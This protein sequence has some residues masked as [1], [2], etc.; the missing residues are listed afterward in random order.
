MEKISVKA[1]RNYDIYITRGYDELTKALT[2]IS[3]A[4]K[5]AIITDD[6]VK[7]L[8][9]EE[10]KGKLSVIFPR[11]EIFTFSVPAGEKSK[12]GENFLSLAES[13]AAHG[14][15]REDAVVALG[16][17]VVGDLAGFVASAYMRG[18]KLFAVPTTFLSAIDSSVGGKTAIDLK[19]GKNLCGTFYQPHAVY[20]NLDYLSFLPEKE[21]KNGYGE[22]VKYALLSR[23]VTEKDLRGGISEELIKK[24]LEIKKDIVEKDEREGNL[25]RI[26]NLGH[27]VGH[28]A[29]ALSGYE[30][31]HGECVAK[32]IAAAIEVSDTLYSLSEDKKAE[33]YAILNSYPFDLSLGFSAA[34]ICGA[35]A[36]DKKSEGEFV[37]FVTIKEAGEPRVEKIA[38]KEIEKIL[39]RTY[40][41]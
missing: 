39:Q 36:A 12:N 6:N 1:S 27:T 34:E 19:E 13:L 26:L 18:I 3:S 17:G 29:E 7:N 16:G 5:I 40:E 11:A 15:Q 8:F 35:M 33:A 25:R 24:C 14:F 28:A 20:I 41:G 21:I 23:T 32:G 31:S 2:L 30:L 9:A 37:N 10:F 4:K 22:A 38:I